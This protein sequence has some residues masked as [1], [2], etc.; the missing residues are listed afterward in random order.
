MVTFSFSY[1]LNR[2]EQIK[3]SIVGVVSFIT[4]KAF[5]RVSAMRQKGLLFFYY[6]MHTPK[7]LIWTKK[8]IKKKPSI[9]R[10][11]YRPKAGK[12]KNTKKVTI[13]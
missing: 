1:L 2:T 3:F 9:G 12:K 4:A 5:F 8:K 10:Y 6:F 13:L 7:I 11:W